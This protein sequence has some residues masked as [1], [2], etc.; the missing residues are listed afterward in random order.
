MNNNLLN[1]ILLKNNLMLIIIKKKNV[2]VI[3][4]CNGEEYHGINVV[5]MKNKDNYSKF[6]NVSFL[7]VL[8]FILGLA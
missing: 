2:V 5:P 8:F 6:I 4:Q 3:N 1:V 7:F